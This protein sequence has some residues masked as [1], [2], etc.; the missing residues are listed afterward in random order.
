MGLDLRVSDIALGVVLLAAGAVALA[1]RAGAFPN[2]I[3]VLAAAAGIA[4]IVQGRFGAHAPPGRWNAFAV[5]IIAIVFVAI[6]VAAQLWGHRLAFALGPPEFVALIV[7]RYAIVLAL[8]RASR[9]RAVGMIL[10]GV[11]L[12]MIGLDVVTGDVRLTFGLEPLEDGILLPVL[13]LGLLVVAD[14]MICI[15]SP[16]LFLALYARQVAGWTPPGLSRVWDIAL[17]IAAAAAI[18]AAFYYAFALQFGM[19]DVVELMLFGLFG[20]AARVLDWNR[21]ALLFAFSSGALLEQGVQHS[22]L[23]SRGDPTIFIRIPVAAA[24]LL[25]SAALL[26]AVSGI[27]TARKHRP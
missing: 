4:L 22:L 13:A 6:L 18:A 24:L 20:I 11:W 9:L 15:A 27:F 25:V 1:D 14:G 8:A 10:L 2:A 21:L 26:V 3:G 17:R 19:E 12:S 16:P 7:L 5:A 23:L